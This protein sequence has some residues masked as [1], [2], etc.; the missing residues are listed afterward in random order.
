MAILEVLACFPVYRI[1]PGREGISDRDRK[2][3]NLAVA[4]A[5]RRRPA[6][7]PAVFDFL[8]SVLLLEHPLG[9][10]P[11]QIALR[12]V[13]TGKFQQV[14]SPVI[15]KGVEDTA[16]YAYVP[17]VSVNEVGGDPAR[18]ATTIEEFHE[19]NRQRN[20]R[21]PRAMLATST[22]DTKRSEDVRARLHVLTEIPR[23]W[24]SALQGFSRANRRLVREV[25]GEPAPSRSDEALFYQSLLGVLPPEPPTDPEWE[26]LVD[27]LGRYMEKATREAKQRTSWINPNPDYDAAVREF[28]R[29]A[30]RDRPRNKFVRDLSAL[31]AEIAPA[32]QCNALGQV[33]LKLLSPGVPDIYQGQELWDLSLVDPDNRRPVDYALRQRLLAELRAFS[34]RPVLERRRQAVALGRAFDDPRQKLFLTHRLLTLRRDRH[35]LFFRGEYVPIESTGPHAAHVVAFGF[36]PASGKPIEAMAVVPRLVHGLL[37]RVSPVGTDGGLWV[38]GAWAGTEVRLPDGEL[39]GAFVCRFT[40]RSDTFRGASIPVASLLDEFPLAVWHRP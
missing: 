30:L 25:D 24:R 1:Y 13:F 36:R 14:T 32:G 26:S 18:P 35:D 22:H 33:A 15:A 19:A 31:H 29:E 2:V 28:V 39:D 20:L 34:D 6:F 27:R 11:E 40:G 4:R 10:S 16:F 37:A 8:R 7:D 9:L 12:E 38:E 3:V 17:L 5:R 23:V 21:L